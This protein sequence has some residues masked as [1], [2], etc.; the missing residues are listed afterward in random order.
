MNSGVSVR[1][2]EFVGQFGIAQGRI[3]RSE[4]VGDLLLAESRS[5]HCFSLRP[6]GPAGK[7]PYLWF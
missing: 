3:V 4:R 2:A 6:F 5:L 1:D 7:Q